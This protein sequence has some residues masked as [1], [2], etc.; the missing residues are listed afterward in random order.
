MT[1]KTIEGR[2]ITVPL[3]QLHISPLNARAN[4]K[5]DVTELAA[6]LESQGQLQNLIVIPE[7][8]DK[9]VVGGGR[10]YRAFKLLEQN[11]KLPADHPVFCLLTTPDHALAASVAENTGREPMHPADEFYA[12]KVL[13]EEG[14]PVED[15]A[16]QFGCTPL[17]VQRRLSLAKV[18][19]ELIEIYR[20]GGMNL[21]QLQAFT[22]TDD[23]ALQCK[24]WHSAPQYYRHASSLRHAL[25]KGKTDATSLRTAKFVGLNAYE[26]AG[27]NVLRDLFGG[28]DSGY[29]TDM[30][31]LQ[32]LASEKLEAAAE[33]LRAEGWSFVKVVPELGFNDV[34]AFGRSKPKKREL[35]ADEKA[36]IAALEETANAANEALRADND[37]ELT[38]G[39]IAELEHKAEKAVDRIAAI[40]ASVET[41]TD[42]QKKAP[43]P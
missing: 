5:S 21:E 18:A 15:I 6:L 29:I 23:Q 13:F 40:R 33:S 1:K 4:D 12:F 22:L 20:N 3:S 9:G 24:V 10:R 38:D 14:T 27:G 8:D 17:V 41:F 43:A 35:T 30:A 34:N 37:D 26:A 2:L 31:L 11:G 25:T 36:E 7:D 42:R 16:A 39:E 19:P 28:P 32:K